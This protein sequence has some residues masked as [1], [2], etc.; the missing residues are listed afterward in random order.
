[1]SAVLVPHFGVHLTQDDFDPIK[2]RIAA[3]GLEYIDEPHRRFKGDKYEQ[4]TFL[5]SDPN[6]N[7]LEIKTMMN[8]EVLFPE[9]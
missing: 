8:P 7:V 3:A 5:I 1:M 2:E 6:N 4:E 9:V